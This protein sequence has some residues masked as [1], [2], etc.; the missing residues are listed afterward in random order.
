ME[1]PKLV[2]LSMFVTLGVLILGLLLMARGDKLN[3][4]YSNL[5]MKS[6]VGLQFLTIILL[7]AC[8]VIRKS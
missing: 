4:K 7:F 1:M 6:R 5:L 8:Y 3:K 2:I